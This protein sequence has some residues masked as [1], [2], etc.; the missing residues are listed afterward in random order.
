MAFSCPW[1]VAETILPQGLARALQLPPPRQSSM[2]RPPPQAASVT[3]AADG[4]YSGGGAVGGVDA[5]LRWAQLP[6]SFNSALAASHYARNV[7]LPGLQA[8]VT[9]GCLP[10][11]PQLVKGSAP[12]WREMALQARLDYRALKLP[13]P[14]R[15]VPSPQQGVAA[16]GAPAP[17][18]AYAPAPK[19]PTTY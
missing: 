14:S 12:Q 8:L 3:K 10:P 7:S 2:S 11:R 19:R 6:Q 1:D 16:Y 9:A 17:R 13:F 15:V 4:S 18:P 5:E